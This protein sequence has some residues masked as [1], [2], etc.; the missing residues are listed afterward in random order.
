MSTKRVLTR[1][2]RLDIIGLMIERQSTLNEM[3]NNGWS[4]KAIGPYIDRR[5]F[6][7]VDVTRFR[8]VAE[9]VVDDKQ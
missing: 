1:I 8:L 6:P 7:T 3:D 4:I 5:M 9:R 2:E